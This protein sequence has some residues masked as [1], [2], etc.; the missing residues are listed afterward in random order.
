MGVEAGVESKTVFR[1]STNVVKK[2]IIPLDASTEVKSTVS[3]Q[4]PL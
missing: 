3:S 4:R 1:I 2:K